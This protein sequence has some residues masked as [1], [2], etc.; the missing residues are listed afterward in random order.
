MLA[1][2]GEYNCKKNNLK[3]ITSCLTLSLSLIIRFKNANYKRRIRNYLF[4]KEI[5]NLKIRMIAKVKII[6]NNKI[7][8]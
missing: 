1:E 2:S 6:I 8:E 7:K 3:Y 4:K 5:K